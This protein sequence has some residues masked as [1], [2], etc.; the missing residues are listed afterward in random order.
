MKKINTLLLLTMFSII[1]FGQNDTGLTVAPEVFNQ[2][3][4]KQATAIID[5][6]I[7]AAFT[8]G[9]FEE[10]YSKAGMGG[11]G[12]TIVAPIKR[13]AIALGAELSYYYMGNTSSTSEY[14]APGIGDYDVTSSFSGSM[15]PFHLVAR[16]DPLILYDFPIQPYIE[17]VAGFRV[18]N[19]VREFD[20]YIYRTDENLPTEKEVNKSLSW[21]YGYGGGLRVRVA[22]GVFI[23]AKAHKIFGS[24]TKYTDTR[25][26]EFH[27][28]GTYSYGITKSKTDVYRF[29][30]GISITPH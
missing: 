25:S 3:E 29:T 6:G 19:F 10:A 28:D 7:R 12:I 11:G 30:I 18:F 20:T 16:I 26:I 5:L 13:T 17:G 24:E 14:Y 2:P 1:T 4:P 8:T 22:D 9:E 27:Q 15:I 21:S 23:N